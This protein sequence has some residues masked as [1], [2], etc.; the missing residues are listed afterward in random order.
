MGL[1]GKPKFERKIRD[2]FVGETAYADYDALVF[3]MEKRPY[4]N[5]DSI[6]IPIN[7][8]E[9]SD[10]FISITRTGEGEGNDD[11][12]V[13]ITHLDSFRWELEEVNPGEPWKETNSILV[14]LSYNDGPN[15]V[16]KIN[17]NREVNLRKSL[18]EAVRDE[19]YKLAAEIRDKL[20]SKKQQ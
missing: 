1:I 9:D 11:Y 19:N 12:D 18:E 3:D 17:P 4:L 8:E 6:A 15:K 13:D 5:L 16:K 10:Q 14:R 7:D 20:N 2:M